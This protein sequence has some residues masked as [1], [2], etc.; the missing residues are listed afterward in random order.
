MAQKTRRKAEKKTQEEAERQRVAEK[1]ERK[2]RMMEYLQWLRDEILEEEATLLKGT[3][4][5]QVAGSKQKEVATR[6]EKGQQPLKKAREKYH[7]GAIVKMG[8]S[9][10]CERYV[11]TGQNCLVHPLK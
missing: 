7:R 3:E 2:K 5:S 9:N 4:G 1:K 6:N 11:C 10:L 8:G